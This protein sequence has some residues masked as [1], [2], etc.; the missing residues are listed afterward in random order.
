MFL[1]YLLELEVVRDA[2]SKTD[3]TGVAS[4]ETF[5]PEMSV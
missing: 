1:G 2:D 4:Q 5:S 3:E